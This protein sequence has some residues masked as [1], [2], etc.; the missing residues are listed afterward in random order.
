MA[1]RWSGRAAAKGLCRPDGLD[2]S[3]D[4][5]VDEITGKSKMSGIAPLSKTFLTFPVLL[6]QE[7][8]K[9]SSHNVFDLFRASGDFLYRSVRLTFVNHC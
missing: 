7:G 8:L 4:D 1:T 3:D 5:E 9:W 6:K 2:F